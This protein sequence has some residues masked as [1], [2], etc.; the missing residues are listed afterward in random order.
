M[1]KRLVVGFRRQPFRFF[2]SAFVAYSVVWTV[3]ESLSF[4]FPSLKPEGWLTFSVM[5]FFS[6]CWGF[7]RILAR[8]QIQLRIKSIDTTIEVGF[9]N[10]FES[11]GLK[12]I[13][14]N[15]FFDSK[16]G[17]HVAPLSLHGQLINRHFGG[18][19]A[20]FETLVDEE[21]KDETPEI[22]TRTS[23]KEKRYPI[24][25]TPVIKVGDERF[26]LPAL[27]Y[28][29]VDNFKA[30]CDVPT[31]WKALAGLW[32]AVRN[33][34][35][36]EAVSVPLIGGGLSG[37]GLPPSQLLQLILLS[38]VSASKESHIASPICIVLPHDRFEE[39][40][41]NALDNHWS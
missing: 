24:G 28:T 3:L 31:F 27:C 32:I 25:T 17:Q 12:V 20:S 21:L 15:E 36:G 23:G 8:Q 6:T 19:P 10:L 7:S 16:L 40:D 18:H 33:Q 38:I 34:A 35:G 37:I 39:I 5:A 22:I 2:A 4:L 30:S 14:V 9:G 29:N 1:L 11:Q 41:L 26:F 13:P